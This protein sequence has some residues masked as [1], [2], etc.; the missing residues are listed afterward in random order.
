M[1]SDAL[2]SADVAGA[3]ELGF[4]ALILQADIVVKSVM[5]MLVLASIWVWAVVIDKGL[6]LRAINRRTRQFEEM[7]WS[8]IGYDKLQRAVTNQE[9]HPIATMFL[10][11]M[12]EYSAAPPSHD[13]ADRSALLDRVGRIMH[14]TQDRDMDRLE[15]SIGSLATIGATAPF[16]GLFGTVWG[17]MNSFQAIAQSENTNLAVVAPGIAE[18]LLATAIGLVAAIPAVIFY[19]KLSNDIDRLANRF[20]AFAEEFTILLSRDLE[21]G[22][23]Q[24]RADSANRPG[25]AAG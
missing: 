1:D 17:I 20:S 8:G 24:L 3:G 18:A 21:G 19:N 25:F 10:A 15:R 23:S 14:L 11:A 22:G 7:F 13:R 6:R 12:Q 2:I 9:Q 4:I 5:L 16:V